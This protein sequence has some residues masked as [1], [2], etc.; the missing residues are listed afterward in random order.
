MK[1]RFILNPFLIPS[2]WLCAI[3]ALGH[4]IPVHEA[5]TINAQESAFDNSSNY[6][7]FFGTAAPDL[8]YGVATNAMVIGSG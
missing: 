7:A 3:A 5:I 6:V 8:L 4:D 2:C 1:S